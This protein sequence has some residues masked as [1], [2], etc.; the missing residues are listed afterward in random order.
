MRVSG[1]VSEFQNQTQLSS[2][3]SVVVCQPNHSLTSSNVTL[4][5]STPSYP[6][7]FEGMSVVMTQTLT[8]N[9]T[10]NLGRGG[11]LTL[12]DGRLQQPTNVVL[13]GRRR[14][15]CRPPTT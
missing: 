7:R 6:E 8:V 14:T 4:P 13:P 3:N 9:E 1:F 12:A 11:I 2:I 5:F 15:R 10:F